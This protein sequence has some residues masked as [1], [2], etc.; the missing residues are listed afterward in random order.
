ML[1]I[2]PRMIEPEAHVGIRGE[3]ED[4]VAPFHRGGERVEVEIVAEHELEVRMVAR[5]FEE[6]FLAGGEIVPADDRLAVSE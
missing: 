2:L 5:A 3:M 1:K 4:G 6:A